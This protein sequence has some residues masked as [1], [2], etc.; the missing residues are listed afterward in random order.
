MS[1]AT[2][3]VSLS[4]FLK[5][6]FKRFIDDDVI[7][8]SAQLAFFFLLSLFPF[9]LFTMTLLSYLPISVDDVLNIINKY[10]PGEAM[11]VIETNLSSLLNVHRGGLLSVGIIIAIWSA[12]NG[13]NAVIR[14]LNRAYDVQE[15]R[16][17]LLARFIAILLTIAMIVVIIIALLLPVFGEQIGI[18]VFSHFGLSNTFLTVWNTIRWLL[19]FVV[20]ITVFGCLYYFAPNRRLPFKEVLVGAFLATLGWQVV[21]L[22]FSYYVTNFGNFTA[23]YGSIGG[24]IILMFWFYLSAMILILGGI[25]N[26]TIFK[27]KHNV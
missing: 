11:K 24:I 23:M 10:A 1:Q 15:S 21:S 12:S 3:P 4:R 5:I 22:A 13:I 25:V 7:G 18:F 20:I 27:L 17:F 6:V 8:L 2:K 14:A 16:P 9:L 19:S 26:A